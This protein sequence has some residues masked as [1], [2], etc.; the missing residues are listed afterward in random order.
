MEARRH[1]HLVS[2]GRQMRRRR[3]CGPMAE[4][5]PDPDEMC[6]IAVNA[7][8]NDSRERL[9]RLIEEAERKAVARRT[10]GWHDCDGEGREA[11]GDAPDT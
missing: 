11:S 1:G 5:G 3:V 7:L 10:Y 4:A 8:P 9:A 6:E 2:L